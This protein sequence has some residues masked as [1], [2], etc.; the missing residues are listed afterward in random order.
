MQAQNGWGGVVAWMAL[1]LGLT[2]AQEEELVMLEN[3]D[4]GQLREHIMEYIHDVA[5]V[6][7][8][9]GVGLDDPAASMGDN[10]ADNEAADGEIAPRELR[11]GNSTTS[12]P[13]SIEVQGQSGK[14]TVFATDK[15]DS[16]PN[17]IEV[18]MVSLTE[19]D[20]D[21][22]AVGTSGHNRHTVP[23]FATQDFTI[24]EAEAVT[25][26][27]SS[28]VSATK[29]SFSSPVGTIGKIRVDTYII[30]TAGEVRPASNLAWTINPGDLKFNI[31]LYDWTFC[32]CSRGRQSQ[33][34][35]FIELDISVKGKNANAAER[36][37]EGDTFDLG[38]GVVM[39][40]SDAVTIDSAASVMPAGYPMVSTKGGTQVFTFRFP[41]FTSSALY[42]P[43]LTTSSSDSLV[44][45]TPAPTPQPEPTPAPTPQSEPTPAPTPQPEPT[46]SP[47]P[48]SEPT[49][50]PTPKTQPTPAPTPKTEPT[51][52]PTPQTQ[53]TPAP[54]PQA[55][56]TPAPTPEVFAPTKVTV[57]LVVGG[58]DY[59][60]L[61]AN[62][63]QE[64]KF[65]EACAQAQASRLGID[66]GLISIL[67]SPGSVRVVATITPPVGVKLEE[68][69]QQVNAARTDLEND[70]VATIQETADNG[71]LGGAVTGTIEVTAFASSLEEAICT[72]SSGSP[73]AGRECPADGVEACQSC[74]EH[75]SLNA[76][77]VC[78]AEEEEEE[79]PSAAPPKLRP[80]LLA[81]AAAAHLPW[82]RP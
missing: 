57:S 33:V 71:D 42:D 13:I 30:N 61:R 62:A 47:T 37:G 16:D 41:K 11:E 60:T 79:V 70:V 26:P 21:G 65:K 80:L 44:E 19:L 39:K 74:D 8:I 31:E 77:M 28:N 55:Q 3:L 45:P 35:E 53:P 12:T 5:G 73:A 24:G 78:E 51:P 9:Q 14:F 76:D 17:K 68:L 75:F 49:P 20:V 38:G 59:N 50:A 48:Q 27:G 69:Q 7:G 10:A 54:T 40:L 72:C 52:A 18:R 81:A 29:V 56:P 34:G 22:N 32:G 43:L 64:K 36:A 63:E 23:S 1:I 15:G 25:L 46:P 58:V 66:V 2:Q 67:L 6:A 4:N 82:A